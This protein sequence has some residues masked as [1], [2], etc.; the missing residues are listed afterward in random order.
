[1]KKT[2]LKLSR[3]TIR[4]LTEDLADVHGGYRDLPTRSCMYTVCCPPS[5]L[6]SCYNTDCCLMVP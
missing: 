2:K 3:Q 4:V 6:K 1:M 5:V